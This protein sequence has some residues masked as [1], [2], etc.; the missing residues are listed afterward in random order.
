MSRSENTPKKHFPKI[1]LSSILIITLTLFL[2]LGWQSKDLDFELQL[3]EKKEQF[4]IDVKA[5]I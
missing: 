3:K 4:R 2:G 5:S 1:A